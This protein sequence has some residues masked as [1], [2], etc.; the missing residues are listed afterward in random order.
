MD[1]IGLLDC[2]FSQYP[3]TIYAKKW[4]YFLFLNCITM[5]RKAAWQLHVIL[6]NDSQKD[7]S[8]FTRSVVIELVK[9]AVRLETARAH[10]SGQ[11]SVNQSIGQHQPVDYM[12]RA[13][14][15]GARKTQQKSARSRMW[16]YMPIGFCLIMS[17]FR[18][19]AITPSY[20]RCR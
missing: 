18:N 2:F 10:K 4:Y 3:P 8:D 1:G 19:D 13:A 5:I 16:D 14:V 12:K 20:C 9:S 15:F 7:Q 17:T 11:R 6:Q